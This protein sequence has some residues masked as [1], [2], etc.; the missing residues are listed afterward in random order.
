MYELHGNVF[1]YLR[2]DR[3]VLLCEDVERCSMAVEEIAFTEL[4]S[5]ISGVEHIFPFVCWIWQPERHGFGIHTQK[6]QRA[7]SNIYLK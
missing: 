6:A 5:F 7:T 2:W 1:L 4:Y 3:Q